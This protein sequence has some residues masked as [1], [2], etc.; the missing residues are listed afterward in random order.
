MLLSRK[1]RVVCRHMLVSPEL[2]IEFRKLSDKKFVIAVKGFEHAIFC[3]SD[4][5]ATTVPARHICE[6]GSLN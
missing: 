2:F 1:S 5:D 4:Q 6:I 3:I